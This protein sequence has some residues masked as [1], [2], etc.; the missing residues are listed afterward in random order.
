VQFQ[1]VLRPLYLKG[2]AFLV[3]YCI[4]TTAVSAEFEIYEAF[5][6]HLGTPKYFLT[7]SYTNLFLSAIQLSFRQPL[8]RFVRPSTVISQ[9]LPSILT[10]VVC[11]LQYLG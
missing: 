4:A 9:T 1:V 8:H 6:A 10:S 11:T 3:L 5:T 2:Y 7:Q